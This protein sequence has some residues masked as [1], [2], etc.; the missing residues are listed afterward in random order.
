MGSR[1]IKY[2]EAPT[3]PA[4]RIIYANKETTNSRIEKG[5]FLLKAKKESPIILMRLK[6][7]TPDSN[8]KKRTP[9][10]LVKNLNAPCTPPLLR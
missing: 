8:S 9:Y 7:K 10:L 5:T 6:N 3:G 2:R 1:G 4:K